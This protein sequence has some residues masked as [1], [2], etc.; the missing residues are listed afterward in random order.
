MG[1]A[2]IIPTLNAEASLAATLQS[3]AGGEEI[4]VVDGG[5]QDETVRLARSAGARVQG[6]AR[7]RGQQMRAGAEM[8]VGNRY[9]GGI[10]PGAMTWSHRYIGTPVITWLVRLFSKSNLGDSHFRQTPG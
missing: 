1:I 2:V 5:S 3:I 6:T 8:V 4:I 9:T 7:G 10:Q